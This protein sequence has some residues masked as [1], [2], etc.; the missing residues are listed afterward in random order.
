MQSHTVLMTVTEA[1]DD[2][3]PPLLAF[4][5]LYAVLPGVVDQYTVALSCPKTPFAG[6]CPGLVLI[7]LEKPPHTYADLMWRLVC[8]CPCPKY[9]ASRVAHPSKNPIDHAKG[10]SDGEDE[11]NGSRLGTCH[12]R[13]VQYPL[14]ARMMSRE[15]V[16]AYG[17]PYRTGIC[18]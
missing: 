1:L 4:L 3:L 5:Q 16:A 10:T 7:A 13:G 11:M 8:E 14:S 18:A 2:I 6:S 9:A 12:D 17:R 15:G